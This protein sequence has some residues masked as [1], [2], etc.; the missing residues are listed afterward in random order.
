VP[1]FA[2]PFVVRRIE[3]ED[4]MRVDEVPLLDAT[5]QLDEAALVEETGLPVVGRHD[6]DRAEDDRASECASF[7]LSFL[8]L[9]G[10]SCGYLVLTTCRLRCADVGSQLHGSESGSFVSGESIVKVIGPS[11]NTGPSAR[12]SCP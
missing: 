6:D 3:H 7:H 12:S 1:V 10:G 8:R 9:I 11:R 2:N 5:L 4:R